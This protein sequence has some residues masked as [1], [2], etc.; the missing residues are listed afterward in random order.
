MKVV[1]NQFI[2]ANFLVSIYRTENHSFQ[3]VIEWLDTGKKIHFRSEREMLNLI[4]SAL[5][6]QMNLCDLRKW[7]DTKS[8]TVV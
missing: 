8:I 2:G 5:T 6:E 4:E 3:G 1:K 7:E